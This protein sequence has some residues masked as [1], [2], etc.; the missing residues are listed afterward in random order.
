MTAVP[1]A[2]EAAEVPAGTE[3]TKVHY[4]GIRHHGPGCA[5]SLVR[6]FDAL[7]PDCVLV[8][9][10]PEAEGVLAALLSEHMQPPVA[11]L[12]Y[13]PD[14]P[15]RAVYHPFAVFSPE[16]QALRWALLRQVPVS[17]IDL[18]LT[19]QLAMAKERE[20]AD[21]A[22]EAEVEAAAQAAEAEAAEAA[23]T[24]EATAGAGD[25][26]KAGNTEKA[27]KTENAENVE[28][29]KN[30]SPVTDA[31]SNE[32]AVP[33]NPVEPAHPAQALDPGDPLHWLAQASG[34]ADGESWWNHTVEERGDGAE[35]FAAIA[36]AMTTLRADLGAEAEERCPHRARREL[37]REA[38]MRQR[39]RDAVKQGHA[40]I[41]VVC[42]AWHLGGLQAATAAT[43][44]SKGGKAPKAPKA[45]KV[46]KASADAALL[47]G[48][49]KIKVHTTWVP[50]TYRHLTR[51]SG[52]G[53]GIAA[54]GWYEHL[55]LSGMAFDAAP[56]TAPPRTVGWLARVA[57]LMRER[58]LDCSS[59]HLIEA[60]RLA[61]TLAALR[62]RPQ[63]GLQELH[64]ATRTVLTL[65]DDAALDFIA[66]AL[67]VG[68]RMGQVPPDVP[69]VPL[70]R[71]VEQQ[72]KSLRLKPEAT[73]RTLD[74][75]LRQPNDLAR[76]HLLHRLRL[77]DL[78][79]GRVARTG[80][81]ARGTFHEIWD[82]QWQPEF[83]VRLIEAS[84]WGQTL[85]VAAS[86]ASLERA[87]KAATL[88]AL[89][90]LVQEVLLADLGP[91]VQALTRILE[92]RAAVSGD[93]LQLLQAL[94]P[95]ASV[96][97]YGNVRQTDTG[98]VAHMLDSLTVRAAIG[99][100][101]ACSG[102]DDA[103]AE[104]LRSTLLAAH[105]A[106]ALRDAPEQTQAWQRAL[107]LVARRDTAHPLLQGLATRLLLDD[108]LWQAGDAAQALSL[109]LS[110]GA[111]PLKAAAWLEGFLNRNA[112]VLLHDAQLWQLVNDWLCSLGEAHFTH[113]LP[114]VRRTFSAF[115]A[116][117]RSDLGQ[118]ARQNAAPAA[119]LANTPEWDEALAE[120]P[121]GL[122]R[123]ILGFGL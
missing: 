117:E 48:L 12:S 116:S 78:P 27:G 52:Y 120:L 44:A 61:D 77:I 24:A 51:A 71:D 79:W 106:V 86:T 111:D 45:I 74:L 103:S 123:T 5:R 35:L 62:Q 92:N 98:M 93:T 82:L 21:K 9:G 69:T 108:G 17:F 11:L 72:Q 39:I 121:L 40:R 109:Q 55:W 58:D 64:E 57:R 19:H 107:G 87:H 28:E 95:L 42:G 84:Q 26:G 53:A 102:I 13:C 101:L 25:T 104:Q 80:S 70:Q 66:D 3:A 10:P 67:L 31:E 83:V 68:Q 38:F 7:Q 6:A 41:A 96:F 2:A 22:A 73:Q 65:G 30:A 114:L 43:A 29:G 81:S 50:W 49:P 94:P 99:L 54:P 75:D 85:E 36:E 16:W 8:E 119:A 63:A 89:S 110:S 46:I 60:T 37:L 34:H 90:Q 76:S 23:E 112:V 115:S 56:G 88:G 105:G 59:A 4:F 122:L 20:E 118:R 97:R 113:I 14:E 100:P 18:P 1:E 91:A 33:A 15:G 32:S 47:K